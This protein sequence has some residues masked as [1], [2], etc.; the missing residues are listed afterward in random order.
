M[1]RH[2]LD[3][4]VS[5][6]FD[7]FKENLAISLSSALSTALETELKNYEDEIAA[8]TVQLE[9]LK[10]RQARMEKKIAKGSSIPSSRPSSQT[11]SSQSSCDQIYIGADRRVISM[12]NVEINE[13]LASDGGSG[14]SVYVCTIEGWQC[15]SKEVN[16]EGI[17]Q[18]QMA[19]FEKEGKRGVFFCLMAFPDDSL[20][21]SSSVSLLES[22]PPH[23]NL[24]RYL[25]HDRTKANF[26]LFMRRYN[27]TLNRYLSNL[28]EAGKAI[29]LRGCHAIAMDLAAGLDVLHRLSIVHRDLK[30]DNIF[31]TLYGN[32]EI[33]CC[34]IGDM[35]VAKKIG[36]GIK[37]KTVRMKRRERERER[38]R[39]KERENLY[40]LQIAVYRDSR[41]YGSGDLS[42]WG[43]FLLLRQ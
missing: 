4:R 15:V 35:D 13:R 20:F 42:A 8:L 10:R 34:S 28:R 1:I 23:R 38:M 24:V 11:A 36:A 43:V 33:Q 9:K 6:E 41:V 32:G 7:K 17:S 21:L 40:L 27:S 3:E 37:A 18:Q 2:V 16:L 25:Y 26:R 29:P 12:K 31:L 39:K 30:T 5:E 14:A 22:L 19:G